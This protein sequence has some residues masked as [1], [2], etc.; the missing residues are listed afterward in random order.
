MRAVNQEA[1]RQAYTPESCAFRSTTLTQ[2]RASQLRAK[3][4]KQVTSERKN[5]LGAQN[6]RNSNLPR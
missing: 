5:F 3:K 6:A 1:I 2:E 4:P